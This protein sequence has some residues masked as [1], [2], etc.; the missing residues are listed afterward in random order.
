[1]KVLQDIAAKA[2][3]Y[4]LITIINHYIV[5]IIS[6]KDSLEV[7]VKIKAPLDQAL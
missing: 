5:M 1:M 6:I 2:L 3:S 4:S 7:S